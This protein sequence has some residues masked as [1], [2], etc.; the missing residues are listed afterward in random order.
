MWKKF[1]FIIA[2][3]SGTLFSA[4]GHVFSDETLAYK[5]N[6][7][8]GL[9]HKQAGRASLILRKVGNDKYD[10]AMYARTEPWADHFYKVRDTLISSIRIQDIAPL[11]YQRIAHEGKWYAHDI[12][13]FLYNGDTVTGQC[14]RYRKPKKNSDITRSDITLSARG[15]TVDLL[16]S[17]YYIRSFDFSTMKAGETTTVNIFSGKRKE[18][19][20]I[21]YVGPEIIK[22]GKKKTDTYKI[23]FTFTSEGKKE[24]SDPIEAWLSASDGH[25]PL[26]L[27]GR[28]KIGQ[29]QCIYAP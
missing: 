10:V 23:T 4:S 21:T 28:L 11:K 5:V 12:I 24:T 6:Y 27:V 20:K 9:I 25:I 22:I 18:L 26:K 29:I 17:F 19:L 15:Y 3:L 1:L 2:V 8:W 14:T 16:T 13:E 7:K